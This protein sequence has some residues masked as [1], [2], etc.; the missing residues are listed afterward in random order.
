MSIVFNKTSSYNVIHASAADEI[1]VVG[2]MIIGE[3]RA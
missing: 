3:P 1:G 2:V